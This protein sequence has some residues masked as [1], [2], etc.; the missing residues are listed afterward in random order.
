MASLKEKINE[1][2][3]KYPDLRIL[4]FFDPDGESLEEL[5]IMEIPNVKIIKYNNDDFQLKIKLYTEWAN[6]KIFLTF[7]CKIPETQTEYHA[8]PLLD[9][10]VA[11]KV[12]LLDDVSILIEDLGWRTQHKQLVSKFCKEL[13]YGYIQEVIKN[14]LHVSEIDENTL[15]KALIFAWLGAK[16]IKNDYWI[17][18]K[19]LTI[20]GDPANEEFQKFSTKV[21]KYNLEDYILS[22]FEKITGIRPPD[23][24]SNQLQSFIN[25]LKYNCI[26]FEITGVDKT[27]PYRDLKIKDYVRLQKLNSFRIAIESDKELNP[28]FRKTIELHGSLVHENEILK[29]Y[30]L[31]R[32]YVF[33]TENLIKGILT[34]CSKDLEGNSEK[35]N[36]LLVRLQTEIDQATVLHK[37]SMLFI[38]FTGLINQIK[39]VN[40]FILNTPKD[41]V[42][43][44]TEA[45]HI[46]DLDY[47]KSILLIRELQ[48]HGGVPE[49]NIDKIRPAINKQYNNFLKNLN[50]EWLKCLTQ[51]DKKDLISQLNW[52]YKFYEKELKNREVKTVVIISDGF[53][54]EAASELLGILHKDPKN[55]AELRC[56]TT[57]L[58]S[59]TAVGMSN[60]LPAKIR[61]WSEKE[62][63]LD[64]EKV[65]VLQNREAILKKHDSDSAAYNYTEIK[66]LS[67]EEKRKLFMSGLV[68]VYQNIVD[69]IGD[70]RN[71][72]GEVFG[73]VEKAIKELA[74][75]I[76]Q[77][78]TS[79]NV[80]RVIVT[81][82]HGFLY[83]DETL[84]EVDKE[85]IDS[86]EILDKS[87]RYAVLKKEIKTKQGYL[88]PMSQF[89]VFENNYYVIIPEA[90]NRYKNPGSGLKYVHG[91]ASLQEMIIP[92]LDSRMKRKEIVSKVS[93]VIVEKELKVV[94]NICKFTVSQD[95]PVSEKEKERVIVAGLYDDSEPVTELQT[96][97][98]NKVSGRPSE[99]I[100]I[101]QL[102]LSPGSSFSPLLKLKIFDSEDM[103]NPLFDMN[104][105][106]KTMITPDFQ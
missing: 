37:Y 61:V 94:S 4:F 20:S 25:I 34:I 66:D 40:S 104:V 80:T 97:V 67:H 56:S 17:P 23:L 30:G 63:L 9:L 8:F 52:Q 95:K 7:P 79:Y 85:T 43:K 44:Y 32:N 96:V 69:A 6:E 45:W 82:D 50:R 14:S 15:S 78:H 58:P 22:L 89:S 70:K 26:T 47:R 92:I 18:G 103:L 90:V 98:M 31:E 84:D 10:L 106:N 91:G 42:D 29:S 57:S 88:F 60:L 76:K 3:I 62:I 11:N 101:I 93:P 65:D 39:K 73:E 68:Y 12:L 46:I 74:S 55:I 35:L 2:F 49:I 33:K 53:R 48:L 24:S 28:A 59:V 64:Q 1:Y 99:R 83:T 71:T 38:H 19:L 13:K 75:F 81:A 16:E 5:E 100:F 102:N 86:K 105:V 87:T 27:D 36:N 51:A 77:L 41:Y 21:L 72:E 54:Y